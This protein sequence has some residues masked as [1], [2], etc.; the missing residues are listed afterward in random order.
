VR[1]KKQPWIFFFQWWDGIGFN[2]LRI[3]KPIAPIVGRLHSTDRDFA[4]IEFADRDLTSLSRCS[5]I[6]LLR[7][8][9]RTNVFLKHHQWLH[10]RAV[11]RV[12]AHDR[13]LRM[14][15]VFLM[16]P[17]LHRRPAARQ[18]AVHCIA[19]RRPGQWPSITT[20]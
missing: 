17:L 5:Y 3:E 9:L 1:L 11:R 8:A 7:G 13:A 19:D 15:S 20:Y 14:K 12:V 10:R 2:I 18:V 16:H 6:A 4:G